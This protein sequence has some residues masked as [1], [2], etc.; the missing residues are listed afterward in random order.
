MGTHLFGEDGDILVEGLGRANVA[1]RYP[2]L[3]RRA[4]R[5]LT[6][7]KDKG[8]QG[9]QGVAATENSVTNFSTVQ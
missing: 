1:A 3:P 4:G 8:E 2:R 9:K 7:L 5:Q 6:L